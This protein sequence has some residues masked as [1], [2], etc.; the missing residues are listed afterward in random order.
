MIDIKFQ[1]PD[2]IGKLKK[3]KERIELFIAA[4]MQT[5]RAMLFEHSGEYNGHPK[6]A[7]LKFRN[8]KP[9]LLRGTLRKSIAPPNDGKRPVHGPNGIVEYKSGKVKIGTKLAYA[10][11]QNNGG[12]VKAKNAK[13]LKIPMPKGEK[14]TDASKA[15]GKFMFR[16]S[17][18]IPARNFNEVNQQDK[19]EFREALKNVLVEILNEPA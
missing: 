10:S 2:L 9:L 19:Q 12:V 7:P 14:G 6:W 4:Q 18:N 8:G 11:I 1:F 13:A 3:N 5:N 16:K 17:V 15:Q